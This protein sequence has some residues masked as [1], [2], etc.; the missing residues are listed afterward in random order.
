MIGSMNGACCSPPASATCCFRLCWSYTQCDVTAA[1][2]ATRFPTTAAIAA[3]F[4]AGSSCGPAAAHGPRTRQAA[5]RA[6][7]AAVAASVLASTSILQH[8][9]TLKVCLRLGQ[10]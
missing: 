4:C 7:A 9:L 10:R 3:C 1:A 5:P 6:A 2:S 8:L